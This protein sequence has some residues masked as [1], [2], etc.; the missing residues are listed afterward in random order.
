MEGSRDNLRPKPNFLIV[1]A[2]KA[3]TTSA[4][5]YLNQHPDIY[6]PEK[7]EIRF[8]IRDIIKKIN[9]KDP[10]LPG[11]LKQS[12]L[13]EDK[14]F[15]LFNVESKLAGEAS[16]HYLYHYEEAIPQIKKYVGDIPIII[17]LRNPTKRAISNIKF[18]SHHHQSTIDKELLREDERK[19][20]GFNSF[21]YSK[22]LGLYTKQVEAYLKNFS[23]VE[24][25]LFEDFIRD[26]QQELNK[27]FTHLGVDNHQL[28]EFP[29]HNKAKKTK[30]TI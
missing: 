27:L 18:L 25:I 19:K 14:Y 21:W 13:D 17:F 10:L 5:N 30:T 23:K 15:S 29:V 2:A 4:V 7:K 8:F 12:T 1:G 6:F 3:G 22:K 16:V 24:V 28:E 9:P 11:I 26:P 20:D